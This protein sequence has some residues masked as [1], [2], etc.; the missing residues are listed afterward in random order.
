MSSIMIPNL[1]TLKKLFSNIE[2][3]FQRN[4]IGDNY[5]IYIS[6]LEDKK[7]LL[8]TRILDYPQSLP[9]FLR[10]SLSKKEMIEIKSKLEKDSCIIQSYDH[11]YS[12]I[13]IVEI[14]NEKLIEILLRD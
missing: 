4:F 6:S 7:F 13:L 8:I 3:C 9:I 12:S 14:S 2:K 1:K 11:L 10:S 5:S